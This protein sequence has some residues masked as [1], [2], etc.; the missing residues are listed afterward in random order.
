[1]PKYKVSIIAPHHDS[2]KKLLPFV[3]KTVEGLLLSNTGSSVFEFRTSDDRT[4]F[5]PKEQTIIEE[6]LPETA[7]KEI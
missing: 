5:F 4:L 3:V 2:C 6:E 1:M 7:H